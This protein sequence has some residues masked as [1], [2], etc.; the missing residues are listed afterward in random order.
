M[1]ERRL[2]MTAG[3]GA[4][5][6]FR[7]R[8]WHCLYLPQI[9]EIFSKIYKFSVSH[10]SYCLLCCIH[11]SKVTSLR[12]KSKQNIEDTDDKDTDM[13]FG[14]VWNR[15]MDNEERRHKKT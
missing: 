8:E 9:S 15:N 13:E 6:N 10:F 7:W 14:A 11:G 1:Q 5:Q 4:L 2:R 12:K 3:D